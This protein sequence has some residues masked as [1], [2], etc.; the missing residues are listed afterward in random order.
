MGWAF[1]VLCRNIVDERTSSNLNS[2]VVFVTHCVEG[3]IY[4]FMTKKKVGGVATVRAIVK[5]SLEKGYM[6]S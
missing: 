4:R 3:H 6:I 2:S 1:V 5:R